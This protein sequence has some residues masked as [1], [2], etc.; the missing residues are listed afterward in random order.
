MSQTP[1]MGN[2]VFDQGSSL[3]MVKLGKIDISPNRATVFDMVF[4][5]F[6]N[7]SPRSTANSIPHGLFEKRQLSFRMEQFHA[8]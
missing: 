3:Y 7:V 1:E 4:S 6:S 5:C 8:A 2:D